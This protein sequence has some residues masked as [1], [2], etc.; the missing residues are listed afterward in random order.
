MDLHVFYGSGTYTYQWTKGGF[1]ATTKDLSKLEAGTYR[2]VVTDEV[3]GCTVSGVFEVLQ[4]DEPLAIDDAVQHNKCFGARE[5]AISVTVSGGTGP[6]SF[7]WDGPGNLADASLEDQ[8][9]LAG[10]DYYLTV[11]DAKG[12]TLEN[13][14][15]ITVDEPAAPVSITLVEV[16]PVT[17]TGANDGSITVQVSGGSDNGLYDIIWTDE[18]GDAVTAFEDQTFANGLAGGTYTISVEDDNECSA[19]LDVFVFEPGQALAL[20]IDKQASGPCYG[21][22]NGKLWVQ[23]QGGLQPYASLTLSDGTGVLKDLEDVSTA[24]FE[25]LAAGDYTVT[26]TDALGHTVTQEV[27]VHEVAAPLAVTATVT[28]QVVCRGGTTGK[29]TATVTGGMPDASGQYHLIL[30]GGPAGTSESIEITADGTTG[31]FTHVFETLPKGTYTVRVIDDSNVLR[32]KHSVDDPQA[33]FGNDKFEMGSD[34]SV[35]VTNLIVRQP[36]ALVHLSVEPGSEE[37]CAG[38]APRLV[39]ATSGWDFTADGYLDVILS[40]GDDFELTAASQVLTLETLPVNAFT[41]YTIVSVTSATV[42]ACEKGEGTGQ[43]TVVMHD[44]PL[45]RWYFDVLDQRYY[46]ADLSIGGKSGSLYNL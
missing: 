45:Q 10:G 38:V 3:L 6:Y 33:M 30:S 36:E 29:I 44:R 16:T 43:A 22:A 25:A 12:C 31:E 28:E 14:G 1:N 15:P 26:V 42:A 27:E 7:L 8:T 34:C 32:V 40:N 17:A 20:S 37:V 5:G 41:T 19:E 21:A 11:T 24:I 9:G 2:V 46:F 4:S 35:A 13:F 18:D 39:A 23:V